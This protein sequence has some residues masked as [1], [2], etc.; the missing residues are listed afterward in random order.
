MSNYE[1]YQLQW[2][3]NHDYSI[4]RLIKELENM[5]YKD[6][7]DKERMSTP[8]SQLFEEWE[9]DIGFDSEIWACKEE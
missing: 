3:I 2:M 6:P 7:E 1:K 8:I 9:K 4:N 5:Q